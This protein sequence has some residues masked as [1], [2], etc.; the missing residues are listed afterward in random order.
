LKKY[1]YRLKSIFISSGHKPFIWGL[2]REIDVNHNAVHLTGVLELKWVKVIWKRDKITQNSLGMKWV[3]R[4]S[5]EKISFYSG[6][7]ITII[8]DMSLS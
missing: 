2:P 3:K 6:I 1:L 7:I 8:F 5:L 4:Y